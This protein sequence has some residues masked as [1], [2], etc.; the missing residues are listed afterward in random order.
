MLKNLLLYTNDFLALL[1]MQ[2][3][4]ITVISIQIYALIKVKSLQRKYYIFLLIKILEIIFFKYEIFYMYLILFIIGV[5]LNISL[6]IRGKKIDIK[7]MI[8]GTIIFSTV[9][10]I[11]TF[12]ILY[13]ILLN[14]IYDWKYIS[15]KKYK[16][17]KYQ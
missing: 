2:L 16:K 12:G 8:L 14:F 9:P 1:V 10:L 4:I 15:Q 13:L 6:A 3:A 17:T 5:I 7:E 11:I